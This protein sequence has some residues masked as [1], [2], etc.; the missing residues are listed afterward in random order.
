MNSVLFIIGIIVAIFI[1]I[2]LKLGYGIAVALFLIGLVTSPFFTNFSL[3]SGGTAL[4]I[5]AVKF[6]LVSSN[7][8]VYDDILN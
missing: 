2:K 8:S 1:I 5:A 7:S 4:F 3:M 6:A